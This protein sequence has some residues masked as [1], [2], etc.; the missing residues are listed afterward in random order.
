MNR[1]A[2]IGV[3]DTAGWRARALRASGLTITAVA[4]RPESRRVEGFARAHGIAHPF[5]GW[6]ELLGAADMYDGI[7]ISTWPDGTPDVL[8]AAMKLGIPILVEKPV[9]WSSAT[10]AALVAAAHPQVIVGYNRRFYPSV[11]AAREEAQNGPPVSAHLSL[12]KEVPVPADRA[13]DTGYLQPFFESVSMLGLDLTR[14]VLGDLR[15]DA[16]QRL[17]TPAGNLAGVGA[18]LSTP[19]GDVVQLSSPWSAAG[20]FSLTLDRPGRRCELLPFEVM[21]LYEGMEVQQPTP[22]YPI[23]RYLPRRIR[24]VMMAGIDLVE[25]PGFVAETNAL[26]AMMAGD[27]APPAAARLTDALAVTTLCEDL[28]GVTL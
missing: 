27:D 8:A 16:V 26:K 12:P 19:R 20:N 9:A 6:R 13:A 15:I 10:L 2:L 5:A 18:L 14:Y 25:K 24:Q 11:Q 4:S 23:R 3:G 17:F 22:E 28:T 7:A 1:V 21:N